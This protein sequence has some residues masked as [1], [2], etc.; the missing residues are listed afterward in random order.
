MKY[1]FLLTPYD[2]IAGLWEWGHN[3]EDKLKKLGKV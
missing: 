1:H 2:D 3:V